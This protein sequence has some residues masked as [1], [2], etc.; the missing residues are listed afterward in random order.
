MYASAM[1]PD[2]REF[3]DRGGKMLMYHGWGDPIISPYNTIL[4][5]EEVENFNHIKKQIKPETLKYSHEFFQCVNLEC[6]K[7]FWKGTHI[8]DIMNKLKKIDS[9]D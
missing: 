9:C 4:Y 8:D 3:R 1:D 2:L 6:K 7:V 5:Y